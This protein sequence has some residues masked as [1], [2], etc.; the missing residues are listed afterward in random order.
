MD[1]GNAYVRPTSPGYPSP[2][3]QAV[4][5]DA[6]PFFNQAA[7]EAAQV[8]PD[9]A[10]LEADHEPP[11]INNGS[12]STSVA[13]DPA[14]YPQAGPAVDDNLQEQT[15][16]ERMAQGVLNIDGQPPA[17][18][19]TEASNGRKRSKVSRACDECRRKKVGQSK[20]T[21]TSSVRANT[22]QI[23]CDATLEHPDEPC[24]SCKKMSIYCQFSREPLKRG[25][26]K[27]YETHLEKAP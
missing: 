4:G 16:P 18:I 1:Q 20:D 5:G 15:S 27:G 6:G 21:H 24:S 7:Q 22:C 12:P 11:D 14:T 3:A 9:L 13:H 19:N 10:R 2:N 26:S 17:F 25:P 23:R 8:P